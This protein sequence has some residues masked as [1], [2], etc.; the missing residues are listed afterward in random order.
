MI[1]IED[2][3]EDYI[4][5]C[6]NRKLQESINES[7]LYDII[8]CFGYD[9]IKKNEANADILEPKEWEDKGVFYKHNGLKYIAKLFTKARYVFKANYHNTPAGTRLHEAVHEIL[10]SY[11]E[12]NNIAN[13]Y[14]SQASYEIDVL[15]K[16]IENKDGADCCDCE[17]E[18][19]GSCFG[20]DSKMKIDL[21]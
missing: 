13:N 8:P 11:A 10:P 12:L 3:E 18:D 14:K 20:V 2:F 4:I 6:D 17:E 1:K 9:F 19:E 5:T 7:I 16:Y 21:V 15:K